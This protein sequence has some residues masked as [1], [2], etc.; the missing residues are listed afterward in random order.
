M[1]FYYNCTQSYICFFVDKTEVF[2]LDFW[3][4][5]SVNYPQ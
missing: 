1:Y 2:S 5:K 4:I 3:D